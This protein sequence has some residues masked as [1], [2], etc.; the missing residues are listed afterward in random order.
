MSRPKLFLLITLSLLIVLACNLPSALV[1]QPQTAEG[2]TDTPLPELSH[3]ETTPSETALLI[4]TAVSTESPMFVPTENPTATPTENPTSS[5]TVTPTKIPCNQARFISD[6]TIPDGSQFSPNENF[7]KTWRLKNTGSCSWNSGYAIVF[8]NGD[9]MNAPS[10]VQITAGSVAPGAE[11]DVS[12]N[13]KAP[14]VA[15]TYRGN[16][17]LRDN[18]NGIFGVNNSQQGYFWVEIQVKEVSAPQSIPDWPVVKKGAQGAEVYAIQYLL[19]AHGSSLNADGIFGPITKTEVQ[20]FQT[21]KGLSA[22]G[23][24]GPKTWN[25]LITAKTVKNGSSGNPVFA[26]QR[27]LKKFGYTLNIDGIFG[28]IT[29]QAIKDFQTKYG[30]KVD[31]IVGP[32]TWKALVSLP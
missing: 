15:G 20:S 4:E 8:I 19:R 31:G 5:P 6:V 14:A 21:A 12:V 26:V 24:V 22:D 16:W 23:I 18:A 9:A 2:G 10:A 7:T 17:E 25:A 29:T 28:P 1:S 27:L 30:L 11:V 13:M 32:E 3:I